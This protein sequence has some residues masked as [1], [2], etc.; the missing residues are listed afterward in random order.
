MVGRPVCGILS[1]ETVAIMEAQTKD[2]LE[3]AR[4]YHQRLADLYAAEVKHGR[5]ERIGVLLNY[6][7]RHEQHLEEVLRNV[8]SEAR[9][10]VRN[11]WFQYLPGDTPLAE[12]A[13]VSALA[14]VGVEDLTAQALEFDGKL[15]DWYQ[16][17]SER[18]VAPHVREVFEQLLAME[19]H[20]RVQLAR[21]TLELADL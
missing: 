16:L 19:Q 20:E 14:V 6:L 9:E 4:Q 13:E 18:S 5:G 17:M 2:L 3:I 11:H 1:A 10:Q 21:D 12:L 7:N 15:I 8:S